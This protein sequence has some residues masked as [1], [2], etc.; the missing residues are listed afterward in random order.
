M[1]IWAIIFLLLGVIFLCTL[2]G[3]ALRAIPVERLRLLR[4]GGG[5]SAPR[6]EYWVTHSQRI[7][8]SLRV[9]IRVSCVAIALSMAAVIAGEGFSLFSFLFILFVTAFLV[10]FPGSLLP[11]AWGQR[12]GERI[13]LRLLPVI[14]LFGIMLAP[15]AAVCEWILNA[16]LRLFGRQPLRF[17]PISLRGEL[18]QLVGGEKGAVRLDEEE[19]R[20][21]R[22][23]FKFGDTEV[24]EIMT[25]RV[26]MRC[27]SA[28]ETVERALDMIKA[29]HHSR[30]PLYKDSPDNIM[31]ILYAKDILSLWS[32]EGVAGTLLGDLAREPLFV[33]ETKKVDSLF[34]ELR[35]KKIHMAIVVD[36]YGCTAGLVTMEDIL[37]EIVGEIQDEYDSDEKGK[38][39]EVGEGVYRVDARLSVGD[40]REELGIDIPEEEDYDTLA[41]F[42]CSV[43]GKVPAAGEVIDGEGCLIKVLEASRRRVIKLEIR[44]K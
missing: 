41:G 14:M 4:E 6:I 3:A 32:E 28:D 33:P 10:A 1:I 27:L 18:E 13:G 38:Y 2:V 22:H 7:T 44:K 30:I 40:A 16:M 21:I 43:C 8:W 26:V 42:V 23:I 34:A 31:G 5:K 29:E 9:A 25:P 39:E 12:A 15:I 24:S 17:K 35:G 11:L 37:E 36:E 19:K 20:M